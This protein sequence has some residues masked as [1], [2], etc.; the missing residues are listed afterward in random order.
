MI[1]TDM[2]PQQQQPQYPPAG[3][4]YPPA[5]VQPQ[6]PVEDPYHFILN[7]AAPPKGPGVGKVKGVLLLVGIVAVVVI[8]LVV[9][10]SFLRGGGTDTK[11]YVAMVTQQEEIIRVAGLK[12]SSLQQQSVKNFVINTRLSI[13][14]DQTKLKNFLAENDI[15]VSKKELLTS[16]DKTTDEALESAVSSSSLDAVLVAELQEEI[17]EYQSSLGKAYRAST[18]KTTRALLTDL[19]NHAELLLAQSKQ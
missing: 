10:M 8:L 7:P 4:S 1:T 11:P 9:I 13:A 6:Q 3:P 18:S 15:E 12:E 16:V 5:P 17:A 2:P 19:N 14:A